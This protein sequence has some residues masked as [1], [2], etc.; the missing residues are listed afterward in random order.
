MKARDA[1][2]PVA[3]HLKPAD[4]LPEYIQ[5]ISAARA[6]E[7]TRWIKALPVLNTNGVLVGMLSMTD[8]LKAIYPP[9]LYTADLSIFTWD[10]MLES[11]A[12]R[13]SGKTVAELMTKDV[14]T[15]HK[16]HPLMECVDAMLKHGFSTLPVVDNNHCLIGML[17]KSALFFIIT[18]AMLGESGPRP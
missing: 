1:M 13:A 6:S 18:A 2:E 7:H 12:R 11:L 14:I 9:Y 3:H 16:D 8:I 10:G 15:V 17:Y 5:T 4:G